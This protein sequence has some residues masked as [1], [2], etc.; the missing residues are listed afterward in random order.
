MQAAEKWLKLE[1]L[2][3]SARYEVQLFF[4]NN[5]SPGAVGFFD[6]LAKNYKPLTVREV[7]VSNYVSGAD[8]VLYANVSWKPA[9]GEF[10]AQIDC[11]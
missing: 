10:N 7:R 9:V 4:D 11:I 6:T 3:F 8:G 2:N 5:T 1:N